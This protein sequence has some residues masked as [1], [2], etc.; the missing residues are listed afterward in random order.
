MMKSN[1]RVYARLNDNEMELWDR[2]CRE[3]GVSTS[4]LI[5]FAV[6]LFHLLGS[7]VAIAILR[8]FAQSELPR[9]RRKRRL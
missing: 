7:E 1:G 4:D 8:H 5:R 2:T 3:S 9:G 6:K